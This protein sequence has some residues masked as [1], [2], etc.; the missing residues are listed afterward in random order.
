ML[1]AAPPP[2]TSAPA[3]APPPSVAPRVSRASNP[4]CTASPAVGHHQHRIAGA[5]EAENIPVAASVIWSTKI[6]VSAS[7]TVTVIQPLAQ[8]PR[9]RGA[10]S[11]MILPV[12]RRRVRGL[13]DASVARATLCSAA[14]G[15]GRYT[16]LAPGDSEGGIS[17][18][19]IA[20]SHT[21]VEG[22]EEV[23]EGEEKQRGEDS[24]CD[25]CSA[26]GSHGLGRVGSPITRRHHSRPRTTRIPSSPARRRTPGQ[27]GIT[28]ILL[29]WRATNSP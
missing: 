17:R 14:G 13:H 21:P 22:E 2:A 19:P 28:L 15:D 25:P 6:V 10:A 1:A 29:Y 8:S 9:S 12:G 18:V 27:R 16:T 20:R 26:Y 23:G 24:S 11:P 4:P 5:A 3:S 7:S